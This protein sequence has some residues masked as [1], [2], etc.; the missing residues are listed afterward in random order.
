[1]RD[2]EL[3]FFFMALNYILFTV[4]VYNIMQSDTRIQIKFC[5]KQKIN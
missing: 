4:Y 2:C 5:M 3:L 1:M